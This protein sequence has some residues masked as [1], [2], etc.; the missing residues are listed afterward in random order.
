MAS[1]QYGRFS[2]MY[3]HKNVCV[4]IYMCISICICIC[5]C[6]CMCMCMCIYVYIYEGLTGFHVV[7]AKGFRLLYMLQGCEEICIKG[8]SLGI[9]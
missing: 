9:G 4:Y 6:M 3:I 1:S 7:V 5:I 8:C 2:Q